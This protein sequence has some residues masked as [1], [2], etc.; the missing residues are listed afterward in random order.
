MDQHKSESQ[1]ALIYPIIVGSSFITTICAAIVWNHWKYVLDLCDIET[2]CGC[3]LYGEAMSTQFRGGHVGFCYWI[4]YGP[5]LPLFIALCLSLYH[6][7]RVCMGKG[8]ARSQTT[9]VRQ[10]YINL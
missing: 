6:V 9:T 7:L 5:L 8:K 3:I 2:N 4:V 1:L 10:R